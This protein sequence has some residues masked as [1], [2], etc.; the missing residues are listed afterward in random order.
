MSKF[1]SFCIAGTHSG[2]GKT[3]I[4]LGLLAALRRRGLG[5]QPFKC[6]PDYIDPGHHALACGVPSRN[7]DTWMMG[8]DAVQVSYQ[9]GVEGADV[10]VT[11]G[12]MGLFD[13]ASSTNTTGST[14]HVCTLLD[15]PVVL[16]VNAKAMARSIAALV[17]GF[18]TFEPELRIVGVIA[19]RVGSE[20]HAEILRESLK[21]ANLPPLIGSIPTNERWSTE[22]RHLGLLTASESGRTDEWFDSL[23]DGIETHLNLDK[24]LSLCRAVRPSLSLQPRLGLPAKPAGV[25]L[26]I[27]RD[28]AFQFYY[29]DNLDLL[30]LCGVE[31]VPFSPLHDSEIPPGLAG[32]YIGGGYPEVHAESLAA[33]R[34]MREAVKS[35]ADAGGHVYAECGGLMYLCESLCDQDGVVWDMCGVLPAVTKMEK[36]L[37]RL[38]YVEA[39]ALHDGLFGTTGVKVRGHEFHWSDIEHRSEQIE[40]MF[41]VKY[42]RSDKQVTSGIHYKNVFAS[43]LHLHF[44]SNPAAVK[45]WVDQLRTHIKKEAAQ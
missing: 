41:G 14:A 21:V 31:L 23:A 24:L 34:T 19:N 5:V 8:V 42:T 44:G 1:A 43:Y 3:T 36:R 4:T 35:F 6:G 2:V 30:R 20:R 25:R 26:G 37:R 28:E 11:E 40:P 10:A 22:E 38:G 29:E 16:V 32:L 9:R 15:I 7:L 18:A 39:S 27:A 13:G 33:N 12:V 17:H 45:C